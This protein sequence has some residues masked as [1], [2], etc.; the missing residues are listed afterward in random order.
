MLTSEFIFELFKY[1]IFS[2]LSFAD[3]CDMKNKE[4]TCHKSV[5]I[6][7]SDFMCVKKMSIVYIDDKFHIASKNNNFISTKT[8]IMTNCYTLLTYLIDNVYENDFC[9]N[10]LINVGYEPHIV[11]YV[12]QSKRAFVNMFGV[13]FY[14]LYDVLDTRIPDIVH[15]AIKNEYFDIH[16]CHIKYAQRMCGKKIV[17]ILSFYL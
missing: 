6:N 4:I 15:Y 7:Y 13:N 10:S 14:T 1:E 12:L 17:D 5:P 2:Y 16:Y 11:K 8:I 9:V 3:F